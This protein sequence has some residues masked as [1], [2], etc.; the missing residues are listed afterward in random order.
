METAAK[1]YSLLVILEICNVHGLNC[2]YTE[3]EQSILCLDYD[4]SILNSFDFTENYCCLLC[5]ANV[6]H[7]FRK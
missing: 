5:A 6:E 7:Y 2:L 3:L 4:C 1:F